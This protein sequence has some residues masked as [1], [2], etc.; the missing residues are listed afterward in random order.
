M[1]NF[2]K[3]IKRL[4]VKFRGIIVLCFLIFISS[5]FLI[6]GI[7]SEQKVLA[8]DALN[9]SKNFGE[10]LEV[11][12]WNRLKEDFVV[13]TGDKISGNL[14]IF[15]SLKLNKD[16]GS[17]KLL[18]SDDNGN[19]SW[20]SFTV[21]QEQFFNNA[22]A[23]SVTNKIQDFF[24]CA[25]SVVDDD[26]ALGSCAVLYNSATKK[27]SVSVGANDGGQQACYVNCFKW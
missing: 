14:E 12:D 9:Y 26:S 8:Y 15:G 16:A 22:T 4:E 5:V 3:K 13:K 24:Y 19:A 27:W 11:A 25:L 18:S 21:V 17:N 6:Y 7:Y 2:E 10:K 23:V 20:K 1:I